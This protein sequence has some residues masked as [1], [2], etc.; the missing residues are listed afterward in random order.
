MAQLT[1]VLAALLTSFE[2]EPVYDEWH[3]HGSW[4]TK[5][6]NMPMKI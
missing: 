5:Q 6:T 2:L 1:K 3:V 4:V